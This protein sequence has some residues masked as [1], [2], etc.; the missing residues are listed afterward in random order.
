MAVDDVVEVVAVGAVD[1][2]Q[3]SVEA[4]A[5]WAWWVVRNRCNTEDEVDSVVSVLVSRLEELV[6]P[7]RYLYTFWLT[8]NGVSTR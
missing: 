8:G 6:L 1:S 3:W 5:A 4:A 2:S 7:G